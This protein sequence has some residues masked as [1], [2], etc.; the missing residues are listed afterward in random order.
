MNR[1]K[2]HAQ[3]GLKWNPFTP[4]VPIESLWSSPRVESFVTRVE[5]MVGE[6][7]FAL[8]TGEVGSGKSVTLRLLHDHLSNLPEVAVAIVSRPQSA[9]AD[10]YRELGELFGVE[11]RPHNRWAGF[12]LLRER[13]RAHAEAS[14]LRPVLLVDE[15]QEMPPLVLN[16]LRILSSGELDAEVFLTTVLAGDGRLLDRFRTPEL[17]PFS[18]RIRTRLLLDHASQDEL[19]QV[20]QHSLKK[21]GRADLLTPALETALVEHAAGNLRSLMTL[22]GELLLTACEREATQLDESIFFELYPDRS[23][24]RIARSTARG[25]KGRE[26]S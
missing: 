17:L 21:A 6:G 19:R 12:K 25:D 14:L 13:W 1:K 4:D 20:L 22:A 10:F 15:A 5:H 24:R 2:L 18:S 8:V 23:P 16:E 11:L 7:G 3:F 26:R 9:L